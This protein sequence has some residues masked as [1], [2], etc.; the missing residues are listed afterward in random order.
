MENDICK[1]LLSEPSYEKRLRMIKKMCMK[2]VC[3][4]CIFYKYNSPRIDYS[5]E[6]RNLNK[7]RQGITPC[8]W[9]LQNDPEPEKPEINIIRKRLKKLWKYK[10]YCEKRNGCIGCKYSDLRPGEPMCSLLKKYKDDKVPSSWKLPP[11]P[12]KKRFEDRFFMGEK[13]DKKLNK[14]IVRA[15]IAGYKTIKCYVWDYKKN[16]KIIKIIRGILPNC[17]YPYYTEGGVQYKHA[18]P[19]ERDEYPG[20]CG[21]I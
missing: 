13:I 9:E 2:T 19:V 4:N 17:I 21:K 1:Q 20:S 6:V 5:C 12:E 15:F 18:E 3:F 11:L 8:D 16:D 10:R 7:A 14:D